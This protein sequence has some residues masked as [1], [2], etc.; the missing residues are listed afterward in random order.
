MEC[1]NDQD[2]FCRSRNRSIH[3]PAKLTRLVNCSNRPLTR[4]RNSS[5]LSTIIGEASH[6]RFFQTDS[7]GFRSGDLTGKNT[8]SIPSCV[9]C[10]HVHSACDNRFSVISITSPRTNTR[11]GWVTD[12]KDSYTLKVINS[13][14]WQLITHFRIV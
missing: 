13:A 2:N 4:A 14:A 1:G 8:R 5:A 9:P 10:L 3:F 11:V 7:I 6:F 12:S